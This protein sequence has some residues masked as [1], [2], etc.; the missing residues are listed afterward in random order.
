MGEFTQNGDGLFLPLSVMDRD[1]Q[2]QNGVW[3]KKPDPYAD[4][5]SATFPMWSSTYSINLAKQFYSASWGAVSEVLDAPSTPE[6]K[7]PRKVVGTITAWRWWVVHPEASSGKLRLW[8][9]AHDND[10][11]DGPTYRADKAPTWDDTHGIYAFGTREAAEHAQHEAVDKVIS[12][13]DESRFLRHLVEKDGLSL[14][15][16]VWPV[17]GECQLFGK[18]MRHERGYRAECATIRRLFVPE[19]ITETTESLVLKPLTSLAHDMEQAYE[20]TV[21]FTTGVATDEDP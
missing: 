21:E 2:L 10:P 6:R 7:T 16:P 18:V 1:Y 17:M 11:W 9:V 19:S 20:A 15:I 3:A 13:F 5:Y 12:D 8:P 14:R 4:M